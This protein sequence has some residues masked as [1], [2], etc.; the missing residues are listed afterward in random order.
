MTPQ[1]EH[2]ESPPKLRLLASAP[3]EL[4]SNRLVRLGEGINKVVYASAHWVVKRERRPSE[5]IALICVWKLLRRVERLLPDRLAGRLKERPGKQIRLLSLLF[6][7]LALPIPRC[8]WL[9]THIGS[10]WKWHASREVLGQRLADAYL[11]GTPL[12]PEAVGFPPTR[13]RVAGWPGWLVISEA[14]ERVETT[15]K[16]RINDL[17]RARRFD[18]IEL[19]LD[20]FLQLRKAGWNCGVFS[21]DPHLKNYGVVADRVVLLDTGGLTNYWPDIEKRLGRQDE[22]SSPHAQLGLEMTLRDRPDIAERFNARWRSTLSPE[23]VR[24]HW[25]N[26]GRARAAQ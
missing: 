18:E 15:L 5:I 3:E 4:T 23:S 16:D 26:Q 19:W 6:Q 7:A 11:A 1:A 12:I 13:V 10:L 17:A 20:R 21:M 2:G 24:S 25:H 8:F 9:A 22:F 14:A